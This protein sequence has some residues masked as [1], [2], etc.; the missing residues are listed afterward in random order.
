MGRMRGLSHP[1]AI[2]QRPAEPC[3]NYFGR[4]RGSVVQFVV[5]NRSERGVC[6]A[7]SSAFNSIQHRKNDEKILF[8]G[9]VG[10]GFQRESGLFGG[11]RR[12]FRFNNNHGHR[13]VDHQFH[14][15]S[16]DDYGR[17]QR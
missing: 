16:S 8:S 12:R 2:R 7:R 3:G 13:A 4:A 1:A 5:H 17:S 9:S 14:G 11:L 6:Y 15:E 10:D